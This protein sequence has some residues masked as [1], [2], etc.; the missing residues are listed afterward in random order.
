MLYHLKVEQ[1]EKPTATYIFGTK[2][3][4][5]IGVEILGKKLDEKIFIPFNSVEDRR[6]QKTNAMRPCR[7]CAYFDKEKG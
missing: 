4:K 5:T 2:L 3:L 6:L 7:K 1:K